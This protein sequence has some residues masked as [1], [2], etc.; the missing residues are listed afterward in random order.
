MAVNVKTLHRLGPSVEARMTPCERLCGCDLHTGAGRWHMDR[1]NLCYLLPRDSRAVTFVLPLID[2]VAVSDMSCKKR[3]G[4]NKS[5][6]KPDCPVCRVAPEP[7][8]PGYL[9]R[10]T[11]NRAKQELSLG[12][13]FL[14]TSQTEL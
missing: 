8:S 9:L 13:P 4:Q 3:R 5:Y 2:N 6:K 1:D 7:P 11:R 12:M 14:I 10:E